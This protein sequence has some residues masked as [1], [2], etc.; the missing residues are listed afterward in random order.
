MIYVMDWSYKERYCKEMGTI[1]LHDLI[2]D[3]SLEISDL[4][5]T[6]SMNVNLT[7]GLCAIQNLSKNAF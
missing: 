5:K 2:Y 3:I 4:Y 6:E 7:P 1:L